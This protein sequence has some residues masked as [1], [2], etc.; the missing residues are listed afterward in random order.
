LRAFN[1][2]KKEILELLLKKGRSTTSKQVAASLDT[3]L[4]NA[5]DCLLRLKKQNLVDREPI[6][7]GRRGRPRYRYA[8]SSRGRERLKFWISNSKKS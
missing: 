1:V 5:S 4:T 8:I 7:K 2:L 3:P 6:T